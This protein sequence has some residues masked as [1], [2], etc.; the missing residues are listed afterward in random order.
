[1]SS[2]SSV[3]FAHNGVNAGRSKTLLNIKCP[4]LSKPKGNSGKEPKLQQVTKWRKKTWEKPGSVRGG[5]FSS[6]QQRAVHDYD[7]GSVTGHKSDLG[8]QQSKYLIQFHLAEDRIDHAGMETV[9]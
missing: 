2:S 4:Q 8:L 9:W 6:G 3:Q 5:Q 7:S 1:M